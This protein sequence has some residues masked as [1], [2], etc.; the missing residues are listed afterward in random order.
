[1]KQDAQSEAP[2]SQG[3]LKKKRGPKKSIL[4]SSENT[5][6]TDMANL[7]NSI[8]EKNN[9]KDFSKNIGKLSNHFQ[10]GNQV[11]VSEAAM[12]KTSNNKLNQSL[13]ISYG[14]M[15]KTLEAYKPGFTGSI[16]KIN[17]I[18]EEEH[19][20]EWYKLLK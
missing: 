19:F 18:Y 2:P 12:N 4:V 10:F 20:D 13:R 16:E 9:E 17:K 5:M 7:L 15:A 14:E 1:M 11:G 8:P 3:T 6:D